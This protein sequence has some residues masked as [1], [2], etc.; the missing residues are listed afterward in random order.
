M[1]PWLNNVTEDF[2]SVHLDPATL[3]AGFLLRL[4]ARWG[5]CF[6]AAPRQNIIQEDEKNCPLLQLF[7]SLKQTPP[8]VSGT[9]TGHLS[10][11]EAVF[12]EGLECPQVAYTKDM[13]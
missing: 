7:P 3:H 10:T 4:A 2:A 13:K 9:R 12:T 6:Q 8:Q 11:P 5:S 1:A